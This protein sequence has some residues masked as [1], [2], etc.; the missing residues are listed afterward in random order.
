MKSASDIRETFHARMAMNDE[1]TVA[2]TVGGHTFGKMHGNGPADAV[3]VEPEA[4]RPRR[5]GLRLE[6]QQRDRQGSVPSS[7]LEGRGRDPDAVGQQA[8]RDVVR[9]NGALVHS[10]AGAQQWQPR[11]RSRTASWCRRSSPVRETNRRCR[12]PTWR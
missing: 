10:P 1:E 7:G 9:L 3:G 4:G 2:L 11:G 12:P 5:A 8:P 6:E